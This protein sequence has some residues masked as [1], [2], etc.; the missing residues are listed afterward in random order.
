MAKLPFPYVRA[1]LYTCSREVVNRK[2]NGLYPFEN[3]PEDFGGSSPS[4]FGGLLPDLG[5]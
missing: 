2:I 1:K 3:Y 5:F 4:F